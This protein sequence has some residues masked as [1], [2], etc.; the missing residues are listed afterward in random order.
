MDRLPFA[1]SVLEPCGSVRCRKIYMSTHLEELWAHKW[2]QNRYTHVS[3]SV[4]FTLI[5]FK[6]I[7]PFIEWWV[8][9][10]F[11]RMTCIC[12][13]IVHICA[14]TWGQS[15]TNLFLFY[16]LSQF[17]DLFAL[18]VC[19][20]FSDVVYEYSEANLNGSHSVILFLIFYNFRSI[21]SVNF[22]WFKA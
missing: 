15:Q 18:P 7:L 3:Y 16:A 6:Y 11:Y 4:L 12:H 8:C 19:E 17:Q 2:K 20:Y 10:C 1:V 14:Y 5:N 22:S 13:T 21:L 9:L